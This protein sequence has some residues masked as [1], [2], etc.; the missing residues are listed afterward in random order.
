MSAEPIPPEALP[1]PPEFMPEQSANRIAR[2]LAPPVSFEAE[3]IV[4]GLLL[5]N[6]N[7]Y[8]AVA[9]AI[10]PEDFYLEKHQRLFTCM[11]ELYKSGLRI[12][13][14]T[15]ADVLR[16]SGKFE[17]YGGYGYL[18]SLTEGIP[19]L[20]HLDSY[21]TIVKDKSILRQL[22]H[23]SE[24]N[25]SEAKA[26]NESV[27]A[28]LA[29][30]EKNVSRIGTSLL[31]G[32]LAS[33][34][35]A[36][37]RSEGGIEGFVDPSKRPIGEMT[38]F[39]RF[40]ELTGGLR[41]GQLIVLAARPAMGKTAMALNIA[42][43][44]AMPNGFGP[45]KTVAVFSL[46][47][48]SEALLTRVLCAEANV[49]QRLYR[50]N[51]HSAKDKR[52]LTKAIERLRTSRLFFDDTASITVMEIAAKCRRLKEQHGLALVVV[53]YLQLLGSKR[54][55]ENRVQEISEFSRGLKLMAKDLD[56]PVL[57]LSQLSRAPEDPRRNDPRPRLSDLRDSGSIEQDAD[58]VAF[59]LRPEVY[60]PLDRTLEG[61]AILIIGKQRNG[62]IGDVKLGFMKKFAKF[63]NPLD[64]DE[65]QA[66]PPTDAE[67]DDEAPF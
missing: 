18:A 52:E 17:E 62:P 28:I 58:V 2:D 15:V 4:L 38:R 1:D 10:N 67:Y 55:V 12:N 48:S 22:I 49:D 47:M 20:E 23:A 39:L 29:R 13:E 19:I 21:L 51:R 27:D 40:D 34:T 24:Q 65:E 56:V 32:R 64:R 25:I 37:D 53:D 61:Q 8:P 9:G 14:T 36:L 41:P 57:A 46:E 30:A 5:A 7:R 63:I 60:K 43:N 42:C 11:G 50:Q 54:R 35:D 31:G 6:D 44:I 26:Q 59:I 66:P 33:A 45:S 3:K 16:R